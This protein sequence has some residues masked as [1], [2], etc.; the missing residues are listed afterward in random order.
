M[1]TGR[2]MGSKRRC[3]LWWW[4]RIHTCLGVTEALAVS[5]HLS[6]HRQP[7]SVGAGGMIYLS[8]TL[9]SMSTP[10]F[11][12]APFST[13]RAYKSSMTSGYLQLHAELSSWYESELVILL[14]GCEATRLSGLFLLFLG[15]L[16]ARSICGTPSP[17]QSICR[18]E[19][20]LFLHPC[21]VR[22]PG[23]GCWGAVVGR[24]CRQLGPGGWS[25][26]GAPCLC[27]WGWTGAERRKKVDRRQ[28][29]LGGREEGRE[30]AAQWQSASQTGGDC[31]GWMAM[32]SV[33]KGERVGLLLC[34]ALYWFVRVC[35]CGGVGW[36]SW[37]LL[38]VTPQ[39]QA[40]Q[41]SLPR[42]CPPP[43][44]LHQSLSA[45]LLSC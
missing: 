7:A 24:H 17:A 27:A 19:E 13:W 28:G 40:D 38:W 14:K 37:W 29:S 32:R 11:T 36:Q 41:C 2:Y 44:L 34:Y 8:N 1:H 22:L 45:P 6:A 16:P 43:C 10:C 21:R 15:I 23:A 9:C 20:L 12:A 33:R 18:P 39:Q 5:F 25:L 4:P 3:V 35:H 30:E 42:S 31:A 26:S